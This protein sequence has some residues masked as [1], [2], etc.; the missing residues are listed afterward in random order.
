MF[1]PTVS[2]PCILFYFIALHWFYSSDWYPNILGLFALWARQKFRNELL[3]NHADWGCNYHSRQW[4]SWF[5]HCKLLHSLILVNVQIHKGMIWLLLL[6]GWKDH[7]TKPM[8]LIEGT[9]FEHTFFSF[10]S[11]FVFIN[12]TIVGFQLFF[13][14]HVSMTSSTLNLLHM[15]TIF[16]WAVIHRWMDSSHLYFYPNI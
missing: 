3:W 10:H 12:S 14:S 4:N 13:M 11:H 7:Q 1:I 5:E 15:G 9:W 6:A 8:G 16:W 2:T